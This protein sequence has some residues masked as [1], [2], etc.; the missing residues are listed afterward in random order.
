[1]AR[2]SR[3]V[4]IAA[5]LVCA[6]C[7]DPSLAP[8]EPE[9]PAVREVLF[10]RL[11]DG[12]LYLMRTDGSNQRRIGPPTGGAFT[13]LA[14]S[15][16]GRTVA[17]LV[18][19]GIALAP[20][21]ELTN[22]QL[23]YLGIP[24]A[25]GPSAFSPDGR[26]LAVPCAVPAG[27]AVLI[28]DRGLQ[29]WDTVVVGHPGFFAAPAFAPDHSELVGIGVTELAIFLIRIRLSD[30]HPL[31]QRLATS[32]ILNAPVFGW[33]RW[34]RERGFLFLVRRGL[35]EGGPDSLAVVVADPTHPEG[36]VQRLYGVLAAPS[37]SAADVVFAPYST[38]A[39][40]PDGDAVVFAAQPDSARSRHVLFA[41]V[42]GGRRVYRV[43]DDPAQFPIYPQLLN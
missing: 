11:E 12:A 31:T 16:D 4:L 29:R 20:L 15:D 28:Y 18:A 17:L 38:Y 39:L 42:R 6:A 41:A 32:R 1:M 36:G 24:A 8:G 30:L 2:D 13:P 37:D 14:L 23:I 9:P 22:Q 26:R 34:T 21:E 10:R 25:L 7:N 27:R 43:L 3:R 19:N 5:V 33:A 40:S 35:V